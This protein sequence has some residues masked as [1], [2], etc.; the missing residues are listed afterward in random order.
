M[1][2]ECILTLR[3]VTALAV[4]LALAVPAEAAEPVRPAAAAP[5]TAEAGS[6]EVILQMHEAYRRGDKAQLAALLPL[7]R[8]NPL[9][10]WAAY[11]ELKARLQDATL[12][13]V[14]AFLQRYAGT[15]QEDRLRN[16]WLLLAGKRRDWG[17][18]DAEYAQFRMRDDP[19]V[20]CYAVVA[21]LSAGKEP[22]AAA[23]AQVRRDWYG[24]RTVGDGCQLA[25][26]WLREGGQFTDA[27]LWQKARLA[28]EAGLPAA[29]RAAVELVSPGAGIDVAVLQQ[30]P[31]RYLANNANA[32][33]PVGQELVALALIRLARQD[34]DSAARQLTDPWGAWLSPQ[35]RDWLWGV[36]GK[37]SAL[38]RSDR[39]L[40]Y[41]AKVKRAADLDDDLLSWK[42]RA[43]LYAGDWSQVLA[44]VDAMRDPDSGDGAWIYWKA[45]AQMALAKTDA[46]RAAARAGFEALAARTGPHSFY[47][48]LALD[49]LG[50]GVT[51]P[52]A[53]APLTD[54]ERQWAEQDPGLKRALYAIALGLR[55]EGVRE[56]NYVVNLQTPGGLPDRKLY[57]AAALAC[58]HQVWD[59]CINT[60]ERT[61]SF[62]DFSQRFPTPD[63][64]VVVPQ[65][66]QVGLD[67]A[68]VY[69]LIRQESRFV[70]SARSGAGASG[71][72][73]IIPA[74][75]RW[76]ARQIGMTD[77]SP[78]SIND[79]QTNVLI[80][81]NYLKL[82][83]DDFQNSLPLAAAAYNAG[84]GRPRAWR[85]GPTLEGAI[86]V[87]NI[88]FG[89]TRDYVKRVL[90]NTV[91]YA[92]LFTGAPQSLTAR[93]G[94]VGPLPAGEADPSQGLP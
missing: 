33:N 85:N 45:R 78:P 57:A 19:E 77:F 69:G 76:T 12:Q 58:A 49:A 13:D 42:V 71:L 88:P 72:M 17:G 90:A 35:T 54:A 84:P 70:T 43:A 53:P 39:A 15:Y 9:E 36:I 59:R 44:A 28:I 8:G 63:R 32:D 51:V 74:T 61:R 89:E 18:F 16:D 24:E 48:E 87:A 86:W 23:V 83:L 6:D 52:P 92:A 4:A 82:I 56:W 10:P 7:A 67:P 34:P 68:Y 81:T 50:R 93:L 46:D 11:W 22:S 65:A 66:Q 3:A 91:D 5:V 60:S 37:W 14:Q 79:L 38:D 40:G 25:A 21:G 73:Q 29:A 41:F 30:D 94:T 80:G 31:M 20:R 64:D 2:W 55:S 62:V 75:A 1:R 47:T 27:D 26:R